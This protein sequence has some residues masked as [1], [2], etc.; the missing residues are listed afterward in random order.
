[1]DQINH[2][3][4]KHALLSASGASRWI[5]CTPSPRLEEKFPED[6]SSFYAQEGTLAHELAEL[7]L[8]KSAGFISEKEYKKGYKQ[9]EKS[10]FYADDMDEHV[11]VYVTYVL[12]QYLEAQRLTPGAVLSI[13]DR[14]DL[15]RFIPD[16]FGTNDAMVISDT[17]LEVTDLKYGRGVRVDAKDNPQ[18]KLYG[19]GAFHKYELLYD[20]ETIRMTIVQPRLD[21]ISTFDIPA[22]E[23]VL[24]GI[25]TVVP[26]AREAY[27][28]RGELVPGEHCKWCKVKPRCRALAEHSLALAQKE[29]KDPQLLS[30]AEVI[31]VSQKKDAL[32]EWAK[33][34][35]SYMLDQALNGK[36]WD[37][38]KL[39]EGRANRK[40]VDEEKAIQLLRDS[41]LRKKDVVR[42]KIETIG[43]LEKLVGRENLPE[44]VGDTL[45]KPAGR[46]ALVPEDD[47]RP[48]MGLEQAKIDFK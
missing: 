12:E 41:G 32:V 28:G 14:I 47:K 31:E 17:I 20:I 21:S 3:E 25:N 44:I 15:T 18:L 26:K 33:S 27:A 1:M 8:L 37:G 6:S 10:A 22:A 40:F 16:G 43:R 11:D 35:D 39:V 13:E 34:V 23:L 48:A 9:I 30:D 38:Y 4:R 7:E 24:W 36:K 45:I 42:E 5:N 19:L 29:F 46:P 2:E